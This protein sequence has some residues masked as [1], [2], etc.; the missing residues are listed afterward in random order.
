MFAGSKSPVG[1]QADMFA[2]ADDDPDFFDKLPDEVWGSSM[3]LARSGMGPLLVPCVV[4][5]TQCGVMDWV[6]LELS[7]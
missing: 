4:T 5:H 7:E 1:G 2:G 6:P 3:A